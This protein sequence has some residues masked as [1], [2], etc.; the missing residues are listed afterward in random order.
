MLCGVKSICLIC[1]A[2]LVV[3]VEERRRESGESKLIELLRKAS[4]GMPIAIFGDTGAGKTTFCKTVTLEALRQEDFGVVYI[5]TEGNAVDLLHL[6]KVAER[7]RGLATVIGGRLSYYAVTSN[8]DLCKLF[9][10]LRVQLAKSGNEP[11][12]QKS[13]LVL[14]V[15]SVSM[16]AFVDFAMSRRYDE[17][18]IAV[19]E[20][21]RAIAELK[22]FIERFFQVRGEKS[23]LIPI[24]V[25]H[26]VSR[27]TV[28]RELQQL[29]RKLAEAAV[30]EQPARA[31]AKPVRV[32]IE[33]IPEEIQLQYWRPVGGKSLHMLKEIWLARKEISG[34]ISLLEEKGL[35]TGDEVSFIVDKLKKLLEAVKE[36]EPQHKEAERI[37]RDIR[38]LTVT[39]FS[40]YAARSRVYPPAERLVDMYMVDLGFRQQV[41]ARVV[42]EIRSALEFR[43]DVLVE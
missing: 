5:D 6:K 13:N 24:V 34:T 37:L 20:Q 14:I 11:A 40:I 7:G 38:S 22:K 33:D 43:L 26:P 39:K 10:K 4:S 3:T 32:N 15:D 42:A 19:I 27:A 8:D 18:M 41:I 21:T 31:P 12:L 25:L 2:Y 17:R 29:A 1:H 30:A 16:P 36:T 35:L 23:T 28:T 9:K